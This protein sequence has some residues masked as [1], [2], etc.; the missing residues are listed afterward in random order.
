MLD[1]SADLGDSLF[2]DVFIQDGQEFITGSTLAKEAGVD[3]SSASRFLSQARRKY[4]LPAYQHPTDGNKVL[5]L[6]SHPVIQEYLKG[7][8]K[9]MRRRRFA[10]RG[11]P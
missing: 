4:D 5:Y 8:R 9:N 10:R 11:N 3:Q 2:M 7:G 1:V 6:L